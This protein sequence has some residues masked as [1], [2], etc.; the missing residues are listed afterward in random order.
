MRYLFTTLSDARH[1]EWVQK[2]ASVTFPTIISQL[3]HFR[4][5]ATETQV[6]HCPGGPRRT[7]Q[8]QNNRNPSGT[9]PG[10][11]RFWLDDGQR[12]APVMPEAG[13]A[14]PQQAAGGG[15]FQTF[16]R[17]SPKHTELVTQSQV[18]EVE[19]STRLEDRANRRKEGREKNEH[20]REL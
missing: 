18:L 1:P 17:S 10:K 11:D 4:C 14:D 9:M 7:F 16:C 6:D 2:L 12:R 13:Q 20:E 15:Q 3:L 5:S 19:G 8:V